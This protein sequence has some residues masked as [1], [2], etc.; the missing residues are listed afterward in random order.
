MEL[1]INNM[2]DEIM[3]KIAVP[4]TNRYPNREM[5]EAATLAA[6]KK[7]GAQRV[8]LCACRGIEA[9]AV[10]A[11]DLR[12]LRQ[13]RLFFEAN[14]LEV[15]AWISSLGHGGPLTQDDAGTPLNGKAYQKIVGLTGETGCDGLCPSG[16]AFSHDYAE[17]IGRIAQTGIKLIMIDD[18]YRLSTRPCGNG[19]CCDLHMAEYRRRVG[20]NIE[21]KDMF[22]LIMR[23]KANKYRDAW[24]DMG[25]DALLGLA[26]KIRARVDEVDPTVRV[27]VC[28]VMGTWDVDGVTALEITKTLAGSTRPFLRTI[29]APYWAAMTMSQR[30]EVIIGYTR[31][32][33]YWCE[34]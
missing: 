32:Q 8:W 30:L 26:R 17:W 33:R 2:E 11:D 34:Q 5:D 24:L 27:G 29:G 15:G 23:G 14:G 16:E 9:E 18:D 10:L 6:L 28:A 3:Y 31:L 1:P 7:A 19:C 25:R 21:R 20:E 12:L 22:P 13:H 4:I